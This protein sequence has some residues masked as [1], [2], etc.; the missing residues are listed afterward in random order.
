VEQGC[1]YVF[2]ERERHESRRRRSGRPWARL[3]EVAPPLQG[4][5]A[6]RTRRA[7]E[8]VNSYL[9]S[10]LVPADVEGRKH[11]AFMAL[12]E[13]SESPPSLLEL[14]AMK[15]FPHVLTHSLR[16]LFAFQNFFV[17]IVISSFCLPV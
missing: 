17:F 11:A 8:D 6:A 7:R 13:N 3:L 1:T 9:K 14:H 15:F 16:F 4:L 12:R 2:V 5:A 10:L